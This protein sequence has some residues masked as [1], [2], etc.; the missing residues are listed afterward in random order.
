MTREEFY[1]SCLDAIGSA[2]NIMVE[3][4]TGYGKSKISIDLVN[5]LCSTVYKGKKVKML[6]LVAKIVHKQ[7]WREEI[8]KWGGIN[9]DELVIECYESLRKHQHEYFD[10]VVMDEVHHIKSDARLEQLS[11]I[12]FKH[13]I[14]LSATIPLNLKKYFK[15]TYHTKI[16]SCDIVEAIADEVLPEPEILLMPLQLDNTIAS[17]IW[18]VNPKSKGAVVYDE[19]RQLWKYK[20]SKQHAILSCTKRQKLNELNAKIL[21]E[22]NRYMITH[23][24]ALKN[25]WL[26]DCG[27]R[28]EFLSYCK[29]DIVKEILQHLQKY[30]TITFCKTIEQSELLGKNCIHSQNRKANSI[31]NRFNQKKINHITA[32]NILNEN[33]N[34]VNCKYAIFANLS[35]SEVIIP[36]RLGRAMRHK[37]P[38]IIVPYYK[39][40]REEE[41]VEKMFKDY[42]KKF[43]R[44]IK[45]VDEI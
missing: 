25:M 17:E 35:S 16:V 38:V 2:D 15:Y 20:R 44:T 21:W 26:H 14:G 41:I 8:R 31:Y 43:I 36:Q 1:S 23:S 37:S 27:N 10:F 4:A 30:R 7:T 45:S 24:E 11:N 9:V 19:Y 6:L 42:D 33:A 12:H 39:W 29:N 3:A 40:T 22:K 5:H 18:E 28:L 13:L 34:L 32:V